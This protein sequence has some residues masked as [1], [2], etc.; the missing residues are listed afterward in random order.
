MENGKDFGTV[1]SKRRKRLAEIMD[2][3]AT[4]RQIQI[5]Q[6]DS[7]QWNQLVRDAEAILKNEERLI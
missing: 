7:S 1:V 3:I 5:S 4:E 2:R 6:V